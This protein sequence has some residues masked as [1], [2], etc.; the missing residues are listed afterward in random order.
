[1]A[2]RDSQGLQALVITLVLLALGLL[3]GLIFVHKAKTTAQA[4]AKEAKQGQTDARDAQRKL[5]TEANNYKLWIG[6][7]EADSYITLQE[8]FAEDMKSFGQTFDE[9]SKFYRNMVEIL[10]GENRKLAG[11]ESAAKTQVKSLEQRLLAVEKEKELQIAEANTTLKQV[12]QDKASE[13]NKFNKQYDQIDREKKEIASQLDEQRRNFDKQQ[14][15]Y[16]ATI[17]ESGNK[18]AK[19][20]RS[21]EVLRSGQAEEDV[22]AQPADGRITWVS[23]RHQT[24]WLNLGTADYLRP[25]T[26][27]SV[28]GTDENDVLSADRKGSIEVIRLLDAHLAEAR[29]TSDD[30]KR[31]LMPGDQIYSQVWD[32]GRQ[33]GFAITGVIDFD[34]DERSDLEQLRRVI[35]INGG[36]VDAT[37]NA[38]TGKM[39]GQMT[40]DTRFL[41]L[42]KHP[43]GPRQSGLRKAWSEMNKEADTL[44]I[45][46]VLLDDFLQLLG[47]VPD[48]KTVKLGTGAKAGDF[49][50]RFREGVQPI[51]PS[52]T[53]DLFQRRTPPP[54]Y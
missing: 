29:I 25:Q 31:P 19:L 18:I 13:R 53:S 8:N 43:E 35:A 37:P 4:Q 5:Q 49:K 9:E 38:K 23:Q 10:H 3:I 47:W 54:S 39:D 33:V 27:F 2:A 17:K 16:E 7:S 36:K 48:S 14:T 50:P 34:D 46:T 26:V 40:I 41:V 42:G 11:G 45:E 30:F 15:D 12:E 28:Y 32:R 20:E 51:T 24:V 44:G 6:F 22:F 1:M 52:A 21:I